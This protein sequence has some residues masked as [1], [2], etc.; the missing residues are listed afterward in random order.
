MENNRYY[1]RRGTPDL[2]MAV[3]IAVAG[4]NLHKYIGSDL[5]RETEISLQV[6]G[7]T[8]MQVGEKALT[9]HPGDIVIIPPNTAHQRIHF[10][11]DARLHTLVFSPEAIRMAPAHFFQ[12]EFVQPLMED[13]L[14]FP[15]LLQPGHPAYQ[16]VFELMIQL[17]KGRIYEENYRQWRLH[18]LMGVCLALMP[19]CK[20]ISYEKPIPDPGHEAVKLCMR[21]I[22]N[23]YTKRLT[24]QKMA[25][26][27]HLH[28][29]YL[30]SVFKQH[31]GATPIAYLNRI[32]V[33][34]AIRLLKSEDLPMGKVAELSGF[35]SE[36]Q[37]YKQFK[38]VTNTTP[39]EYAAKHK[40]NT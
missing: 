9:C 6:S 38:L 28:P 1:R 27:C 18:L 26:H 4:V 24:L 22:H 30:C 15:L 25:E 33:E 13:R 8:H 2:P 3:Y 23:N 29:N 31:A 36:C 10:S 5:H 39:K 16:M 14:Q 19:H 7:T 17:E 35:H 34:N 20:V 12:T 40:A 11:E 32:R 21:Y 37:F